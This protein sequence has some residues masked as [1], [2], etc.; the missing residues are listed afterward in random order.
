MTSPL[1]PCL[2]P[3]RY[4]RPRIAGGAAG[5]S[6]RSEMGEIIEGGKIPSAQVV[7]GEGRQSGWQTDAEAGFKSP[8]NG[9]LETE[10]TLV[11]G[12]KPVSIGWEEGQ[13]DGLEPRQPV[14]AR[15]R[16]GKFVAGADSD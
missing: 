15:K 12:I 13:L 5:S 4:R 2:D 1:R 8:K 6:V 7:Q 3:G 14:D 10:A 11:I 9:C 16:T